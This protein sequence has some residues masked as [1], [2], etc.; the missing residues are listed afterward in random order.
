[1]NWTSITTLDVQKAGP[2]EVIAAA[3]AK[4]PGATAEAIADA[5][6]DVRDAISPGNSLDLDATKV[7]NSLKRLTTRRAFFA[8]AAVIQ[9]ELNKDLA[10]LKNMDERRLNKITDQQRRVEEPDNPDG[11]AE[12]Q[13]Q[14]T[15]HIH[16][17]HRT[18]TLRTTDGI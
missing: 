16:R 1:M 11:Q 14:P 5:V 10:E 7:P 2:P 12:I 17:R 8:L 15:P 9:Y 4:T 18:F 13:S 3:E 6:A